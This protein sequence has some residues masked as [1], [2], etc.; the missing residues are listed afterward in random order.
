MNTNKDSKSCMTARPNNEATQKQPA[1]QNGTFASQAFK[2]AIISPRSN[3][4]CGERS[5]V[6]AV[7]QLQRQQEKLKRQILHTVHPSQ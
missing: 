7:V 5:M 3:Q 1:Q 2:H 4:D 6:S